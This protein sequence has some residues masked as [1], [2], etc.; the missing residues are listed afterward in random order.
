MLN[1]MKDDSDA[2]MGG[3]LCIEAG[4]EVESAILVD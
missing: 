1:P 3:V 2:M 4:V